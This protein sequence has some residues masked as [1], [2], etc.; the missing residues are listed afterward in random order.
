M[1]VQNH[2]KGEEEQKVLIQ[3]TTLWVN[4]HNSGEVSWP[5]YRS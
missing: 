5:Q 1:V 3:W 2:S 4:L